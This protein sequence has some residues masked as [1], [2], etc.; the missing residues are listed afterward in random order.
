MSPFSKRTALAALFA[1]STLGYAATA[2]QADDA[3][4]I[5]SMSIEA[6]TAT[7]PLHV[8]ST[9]GKTWNEFK[10][11]S[12]PFSAKMKIDT[13][14]PGY[15]VRVGVV[16]G[17][18]SGDTCESMPQLWAEEPSSRDWSGTRNLSIDPAQIPLSD[19]DGIA[20][21]SDGDAI[22]NKCNAKL[23]ADGPTKSHSF[24]HTFH[25]TFV[26]ETGTAVLDSNLGV[27]EAGSNSFPHDIHHARHDSFP[28]A[29]I[30]D[31]IMPP[32]QVGDLQTD[33]GEF[34]AED[35]KLF[36]ATFRH[37]GSNSGNAGTQ[38]RALRVTARVE[39]S[40]AGP[41]DIRLWRQEGN[42]PI[43]NEFKS[44]W[45]SYDAKKNGYFAD[46]VESETFK[47]TTWLQ[48]MAEVI[49]DTSAPQTGWKGIT[50]H[51]TGA[52][53][54]G[55]T[56][57]Q[58]DTDGI[59]PTPK[60]PKPA[61][62]LNN[63]D[64]ASPTP[65]NPDGPKP[66]WA[67]EVTLADSAAASKSCPRKGQVF[68]AVTRNEPGNFKYRLGCSNGASFSGTAQAFSQGGPTFEAYG[69][70][71]FSINRTRSIQCTLQEVK[72]NGAAVTIDKGSLAYTCNNPAIDPA[73]DGLTAPQ[74]PAGN[75][76][77]VN[78]VCRSGFQQVGHVCVRKSA[79]VAPCA[80]N[81]RRVNGQ[82]FP[83]R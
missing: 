8:I 11:G 62:D 65:P 12:V 35:I 82:C 48:Y 47:A 70:H 83:N 33:L 32:P 69:A 34:R 64:M 50:V 14:W 77:N 17:A 52:G 2:A 21:I 59:P 78:I 76:S 73:Q 15:V 20:V 42:G 13:K 60:Q 54:G 38:C 63:Q 28:V 22:L 49:G 75:N 68:F 16:L 18:C 58:G 71:D 26:A 24:S 57:D 43:T 31:A 46:F 45:A 5:K 3:A 55:L 4:K 7:A 66:S 79:V 61:V 51:C 36:L 39:T 41:V 23:Q 37:T 74:I 56:V 80:K 30:C 40:K 72:S 53:G 67:G 19:Q 1:T 81:E 44:A 25:A 27:I 6:Y 10:S 29:V 9:D